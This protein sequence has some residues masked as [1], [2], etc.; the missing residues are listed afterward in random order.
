M[1][2][3]K[4]ID[5][6]CDLGESFGSYQLGNDSE[7]LKYISSANIACGFHAGDPLVIQQTI[8]AALANNVAIGAHPGFPDLVGFGRRIMQ[9][10]GAE[11]FSL[12][13]YQVGA[14]KGMTEALG[15]QLQHVKPH[16]ALYNMAAKDYKMAQT[17]ARAVYQIDP[18]LIVV[19]LA[20]STMMDAAKDMGLSVISEAFADRAYTPKG[21]LVPRSEKGA[22]IHDQNQSIEQVLQIIEQQS[23]KANDDSWVNLEAHTV[24]LHGDNPQAIEFARALKETIEGKGYQIVAMKKLMQ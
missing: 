22:V 9:V 3:M 18:S 13:L 2:E 8:E 21:C 11:L 16:G 19:G 4:Q 15:G 1:Q 6:N 12:V 17:I 24:C 10:S 5:L 23:V 20:N 14:L 7:I